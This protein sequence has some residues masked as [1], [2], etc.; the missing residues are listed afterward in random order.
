MKKITFLLLIFSSAFMLF[1][2]IE[3]GDNGK[4]ETIKASTIDWNIFKDDEDYHEIESIMNMNIDGNALDDVNDYPAFMKLLAENQSTI[5]ETKK[6]GY[7]TVYLI[8]DK[9]GSFSLEGG[10]GTYDGKELTFYVERDI[11]KDYVK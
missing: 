3:N 2:C 11:L 5:S 10:R 6:D 9:Q 1:G 4:R 7:V 8:F